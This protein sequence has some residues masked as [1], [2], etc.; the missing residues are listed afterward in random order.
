MVSH[1]CS[2]DSLVILRC[3]T[4]QRRACGTCGCS[5]LPPACRVVHFR[6]LRG[7][8]VLVHRVSERAWGLRLRRA[9]QKLAVSFLTM[10][11]SATN[12]SR[13]PPIA[14]F[15]SSIPSPPVPLF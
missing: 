10:L 6:H 5:L 13:G 7:L 14:A 8:P 1:L 11:P 4:P 15:R 2:N 3:P 9:G 12:D